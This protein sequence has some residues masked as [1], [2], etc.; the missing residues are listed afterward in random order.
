MKQDYKHGT[1]NERMGW[2]GRGGGILCTIFGELW[3]EDL[4][5]PTFSGCWTGVL[6]QTFLKHTRFDCESGGRKV[7]RQ[8]CC[9]RWMVWVAY[10]LLKGV[11]KKK[12]CG[13]I[14]GRWRLCVACTVLQ[15]TKRTKLLTPLWKKNKKKETTAEIRAWPTVTWDTAMP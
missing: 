14:L 5:V 3:N 7:V 11:C 4:T 10:T 2:G 6:L 15:D 12:G 8:P 9:R 1:A 13:T